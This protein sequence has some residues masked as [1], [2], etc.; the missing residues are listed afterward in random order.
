[1]QAIDIVSQLYTAFWDVFGDYKSCNQ[2]EFLKSNF[3]SEI[4]LENIF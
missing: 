2:H 3:M 1:M 4:A